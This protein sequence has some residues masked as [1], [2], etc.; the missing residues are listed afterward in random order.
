MTTNYVSYHLHIIANGS[1]KRLR[2]VLCNILPRN[3]Y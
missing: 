3:D 1:I 2:G